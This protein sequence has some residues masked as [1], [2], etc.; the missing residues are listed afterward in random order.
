MTEWILTFETN[1]CGLAEE[2]CNQA[3]KVLTGQEN[4][5]MIVL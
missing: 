3:Q 5:G 2:L 1:L 4:Y